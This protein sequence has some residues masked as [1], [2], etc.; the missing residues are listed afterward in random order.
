MRDLIEFGRAELAIILGS[1]LD[2]SCDGYPV[3]LSLDFG[4]V[5]GLSPS[6][7]SGH[8]GEFRECDVCGRPCLFILGRKHLY[9]DCQ[10]EIRALVRFVASL[11]V[12][13]LLIT[14]AAGSLDRRFSPGEFVLVDDIV[15]FQFRKSWSGQ[16]DPLSLD[17]PLM[18]R[19]GEA[20]L[21]VGLPLHRGTLACCPGPAFE[22]RAEVQA[23][24]HTGA[25]LVS[26]SGAP[27]VHYA[28][29]IGLKVAL[30]CLTTNFGTGL[31][32]RPP[33]HQEVLEVGREASKA[34]NRL[35][36]Q[37]VKSL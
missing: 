34:M 20:A 28:N 29:L 27:E 37:L 18:L 1:G 24:Q 5:P 25:T 13:D 16:R 36:G 12:R 7:V 11:G 35:I 23:L 21:E 3:A 19:L 4:E 8:R 31:S 9:E 10:E 17:Q 33:C 2:G 32:I 26:M 6:S 22:T 30:L 14:S 15:D